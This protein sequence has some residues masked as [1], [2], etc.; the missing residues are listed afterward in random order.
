MFT[1]I[2][3]ILLFA[4]TLVSICSFVTMIIIELLRMFGRVLERSPLN[5]PLY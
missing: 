5:R 4:I 2:F 3:L 1:L